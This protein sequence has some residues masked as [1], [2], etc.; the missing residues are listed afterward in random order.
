MSLFN[1]VCGCGPVSGSV[2]AAFPSLSVMVTAAAAVTILFRW[3]T[4]LRRRGDIR[5]LEI[6]RG[7]GPAGQASDES[8]RICPLIKI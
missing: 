5:Q 1:R 4:I 8:T 7:Y 6:R 2:D 3:L